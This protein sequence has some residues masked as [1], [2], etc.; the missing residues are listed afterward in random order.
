MENTTDK[1]PFD[2]EMQIE[3]AELANA[4][5]EQLE[6][7]LTARLQLPRRFRRRNLLALLRSGQIAED[8]LISQWL[9][10]YHTVM[11]YA[12]ERASGPPRDHSRIEEQGP[13]EAALAAF[14]I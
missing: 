12:A 7:R 11:E 8:E 4:A 1:S 14:G 5:L 13:P 2:R 3:T 10:A 9:A 6:A